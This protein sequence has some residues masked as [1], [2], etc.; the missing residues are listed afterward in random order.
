MALQKG[1]GEGILSLMEAGKQNERQEGGG[2]VVKSMS[3]GPSYQGDP[4]GDLLQESHLLKAPSSANGAT[5]RRQRVQPEALR[6]IP[7]L[8]PDEHYCIG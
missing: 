8:K 6:H 1:M 7:S 3:Q 2:Y 5:G 4:E